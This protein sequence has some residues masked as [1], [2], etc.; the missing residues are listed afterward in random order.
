MTKEC[1]L[2]ELGKQLRQLPPEEIAQHQAYYEELLEDMLEDGMS[3]EDAVAK[4]GD[5]SVIAQEILQNTPL[6]TLVKGRF[7]P[8]KEW[9]IP[10]VLLLILGA[11]LWL[12]LSLA[13]VI[14]AAAILFAFGV[15]VAALFAVVLSLGI[16]GIAVLFKSLTLFSLGGN[17]SLFALGA[18]CLLL[19]LGCLAFLAAEQAAIALLRGGRWIYRKLKASLIKKE[20][21]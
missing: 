5:L 12:P 2:Q 19:G 1:F 16:A 20:G 14:S 18:G 11:P 13:L 9:S 7:R 6:P 10:V 17:Y 15:V 3:E 21:T 8:K 4:L